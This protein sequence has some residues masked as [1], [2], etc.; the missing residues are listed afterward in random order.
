VAC[1]RG[2]IGRDKGSGAYDDLE[3]IFD[4]RRILVEFGI[5]VGI[6]LGHLSVRVWRVGQQY[7]RAYQRVD[8]FIN[9]FYVWARRII[10]DNLDVVLVTP[11]IIKGAPSSIDLRFLQGWLLH[12]LA[13]P[14]IDR[15][16]HL[17]QGISPKS[18]H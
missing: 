11:Y 12:I 13:S 10:D 15:A 7:G 3:T 9:L 2:D 16:Y 18:P 1:D 4:Q 14:T 8:G 5:N 17:R 6:C